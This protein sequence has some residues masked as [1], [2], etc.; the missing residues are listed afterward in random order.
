MCLTHPCISQAIL[1]LLPCF[2]NAYFMFVASFK[3][4][5]YDNCPDFVQQKT[6]LITID[7]CAVICIYCT[8]SIHFTSC[9][10]PCPSKPHLFNHIPSFHVPL[11]PTSSIT[12]H[13]PMS[14]YTPPLQSH[15]ILP[16]FYNTPTSSITCHLPMSLYIPSSSITYHLTILL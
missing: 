9:S 7:N 16:S 15:T 2:E 11:Y 5:I 4:Q 1:I 6:I 12:C 14:L 13:L 10:F 8:T 3:G